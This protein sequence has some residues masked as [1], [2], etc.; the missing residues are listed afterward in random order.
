M[1]IDKAVARRHRLP[2][3]AALTAQLVGGVTIMGIV[4]YL[5]AA[6]L[7]SLGLP[8]FGAVVRDFAQDLADYNIPARVMIWI[9]GAR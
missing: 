8:A 3:A 1:P 2:I 9:S 4:V 6:Y 5:T 7:I